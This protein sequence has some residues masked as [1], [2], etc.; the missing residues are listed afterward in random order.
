MK[1]PESLMELWFSFLF[2]IEETKT[3][4]K[5]MVKDETPDD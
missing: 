1:N 2:V 5:N 4:Y 3:E